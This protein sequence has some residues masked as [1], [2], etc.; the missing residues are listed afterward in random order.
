[1][2][3]NTKAIVLNSF[4]YQE[5]SII[6]KLYTQSF[7]LQSYIVKGLR[8]KNRSYASSVFMPLQIIDAEVYNSGRQ[9]LNILK[10]ANISEGLHHLHTSIVK[11]TLTLFLSEIILSSIRGEEAEEVVFQYLF[12]AI[13]SLNNEQDGALATFHLRFMID[14][15][16]ILGFN[17]SNYDLASLNQLTLTSFPTDYNERLTREDRNLWLSTLISFYEQ[18]ITIGHKIVSHRV[19]H[20]ILH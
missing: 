12:N 2:L 3:H 16:G 5:S 1:M 9:G 17:I 10:N 7:G 13:K 15:A 20:D 8:Q 14:F 18:H 11:S 6:T 4:P 19:L